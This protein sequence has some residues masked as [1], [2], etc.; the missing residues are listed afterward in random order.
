MVYVK[1]WNS[2]GRRTEF[3][4]ALESR[5]SSFSTPTSHRSVVVSADPPLVPPPAP[6]PAAADARQSQPAQ[7]GLRRSPV[8]VV[9][10]LVRRRRQWLSS[11]G[12]SSEYA[13]LS[14]AQWLSYEYGPAAAAA[15]TDDAAAVATEPESDADTHKPQRA[16]NVATPANAD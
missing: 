10:T 1:N 14:H 9:P 5:A 4:L 8:S 6:S 2:A 7:R 13:R 16:E 15:A 3:S 11:H 12:G